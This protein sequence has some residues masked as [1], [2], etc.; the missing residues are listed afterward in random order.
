MNVLFAHI[1]IKIKPPTRN[2]LL[3]ILSVGPSMALEIGLAGMH[4]TIAFN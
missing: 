3:G 4:S 2:R 1:P